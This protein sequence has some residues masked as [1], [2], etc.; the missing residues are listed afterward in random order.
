MWV[1][2]HYIIRQ[3]LVLSTGYRLQNTLVTD[4]PFIQL[5][6]VIL[7]RKLTSKKLK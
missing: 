6:K 2:P 3:Y 5:F 1:S 4:G 7:F